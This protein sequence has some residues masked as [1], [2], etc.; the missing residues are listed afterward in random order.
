M[1]APLDRAV[2]EARFPERLVR[3]EG[4]SFDARAGAV[5]ARRRLRFGPLVLEET[6]LAGADPAVIAAAL[7]D[8][9]GER[10]LRDLDWTGA[11]RQ[12]QAR[13]L[14]MRKV[15]GES[16]PDVSD[17]ALAATASDWLA[18]HLAGLTRLSELKS[19]NLAPILTGLLPWDRQRRLDAALPA[20]IA[21]PGGRS[22]AVDYVRDTPTLEARAQ[23]LYGLADLPRLAEGR[24]PLQAALLSPAGRPVAVTGDLAR[25][26]TSG[27]ADVRKDMR[28]RY[29]KHDWPENPA[30]P[31]G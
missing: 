17:A 3:E 12:A 19:L 14:W 24:V 13:I 2:L 10:G 31:A 9:A 30:R 27:W 1:A 23:H 18:P 16:W 20:R 6:P 5:L 26:W 7:A 4:A 22:A 8:A 25:F 21:L 11:A 15:E 28:G 29:P